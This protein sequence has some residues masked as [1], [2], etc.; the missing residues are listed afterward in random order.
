[1]FN[2]GYELLKLCID[3]NKKVYEIVIE[4]ELEESNITYDE[5]MDKMKTI[6]DTMKNSAS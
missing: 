2:K 1:M 3:N 6:L 5:L 4:K